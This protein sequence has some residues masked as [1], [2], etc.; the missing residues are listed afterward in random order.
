MKCIGDGKNRD[1]VVLLKD[2]IDVLTKWFNQ[3][4]A[5][6]DEIETSDMSEEEKDMAT[7]CVREE[8][9]DILIKLSCAYHKVHSD[10]YWC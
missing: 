9:S 3:N 6:I 5:Y 4:V 1:I 7:R 10:N 8:N 2:R